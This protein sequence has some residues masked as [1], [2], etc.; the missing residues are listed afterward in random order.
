M[1]SIVLLVLC[2][3]GIVLLRWVVLKY[4]V[5]EKLE[6]GTVAL[7]SIVTAFSKMTIGTKV[8]NHAGFMTL[9]E[10]VIA[11]YDFASQRV[12]GQG[13]ISLPDYACD[14]VSGGIGK[15]TTGANGIAE[16]YVVRYY[17]GTFSMFLRREM[18]SPVV[19]VNAIVYTLEAYLAD[20]DINEAEAKRVT[21]TGA[22]HVL[23][24]ILATDGS[25][26]VYS[27]ERFVKNL[28]GG[29]NEALTWTADEIRTKASEIVPGNE[30][31][32]TVAD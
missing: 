24:A 30:T 28:A 9:L 26:P 27:Y 7:A 16:D 22:T 12:P 10:T 4:W 1:M 5:K 18:A 21:D 11:G 13:F 31:Y 19:A 15:K 20:P 25:E 32:M 6:L 17:R 2:V 8:V 29:N 14:M 23:V 3:I